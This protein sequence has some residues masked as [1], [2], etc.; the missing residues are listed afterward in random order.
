M[1]RSEWVREIVCAWIMQVEDNDTLR[2]WFEAIWDRM[3]R[4]KSWTDNEERIAMEVSRGLKGWRLYEV[5]TSEP[6]VRARHEGVPDDYSAIRQN[7]TTRIDTVTLVYKRE[8]FV[9]D[10]VPPWYRR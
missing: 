8:V 5:T 6:A 10:G 4:L 1:I 2:D 7:V 9:S 3:C